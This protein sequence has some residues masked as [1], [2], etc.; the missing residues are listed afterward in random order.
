[1][2]LVIKDRVLETTTTTG[3]GTLSLDGAVTGYQSFG[4]IGDGNTTPY[5]VFAVDGSGVPTGDWETGIGTYTASGTTL[6]RTT[7]VESSNSNAAVSF[8]AGTKVVAC[9]L[10]ADYLSG[11][12]GGGGAVVGESADFTL[13][14]G[15]H[16]NGCKIILTPGV[17]TAYRQITLMPLAGQPTAGYV[18]DVYHN[19]PGSPLKVVVNAGE[20]SGVVAS[21]GTGPAYWARLTYVGS[22]KW[23]VSIF[24]GNASTDQNYLTNV[25]A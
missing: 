9:G 18:A 4:A 11:L 8:S 6:A 10:T 17:G 23:L 15:S 12:G 7:V 21:P 5:T 14:A 13:D 1:M 24:S 20:G 25:D 22:N 3:T 19:D 16:P 2:A